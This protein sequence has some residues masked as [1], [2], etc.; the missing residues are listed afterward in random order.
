IGEMNRSSDPS[1][2]VASHQTTTT[3]ATAP[4]PTSR[5]CG[6]GGASRSV[7]SGSFAESAAIYF[8]AAVASAGYTFTSTRRFLAPFSG[9]DGSA[10]LSQPSPVV[11]NWFGCSDG[12]FLTSASFTELARFSDSSW[13]RLFGTVP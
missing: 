11:E 6:G 10:G 3:S 7:K 13:T 8:G 1:P 9:S 5:S 2:L 4:A 12:N